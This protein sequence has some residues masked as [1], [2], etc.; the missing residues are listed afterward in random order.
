MG[1]FAIFNFAPFCVSSTCI[2]RLVQNF[3]E[4]LILSLILDGKD[5]A[6]YTS[7]TVISGS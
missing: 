1:N 3:T 2:W 5:M 4:P 6:L 7:F